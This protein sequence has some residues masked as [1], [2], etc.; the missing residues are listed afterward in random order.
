VRPPE[1]SED[2]SGYLEI[3]RKERARHERPTYVVGATYYD[4]ER[5]AEVRFED[6]SFK[7]GGSQ[8]QGFGPQWE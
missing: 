5:V 7:K 6:R 1:D 2:K 4:N 3:F 8:V